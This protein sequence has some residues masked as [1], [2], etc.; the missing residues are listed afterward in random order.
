MARPLCFPRHALGTELGGFRVLTRERAK[1]RG[2]V[3]GSPAYDKYLYPE[4]MR[5][6]SAART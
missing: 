2:L 4:Q 3:F 6:F 5:H 1:E